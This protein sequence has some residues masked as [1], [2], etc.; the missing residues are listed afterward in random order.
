MFN[1]H[2]ST[3]RAR[4][5]LPATGTNDDNDDDGDR[6]EDADDYRLSSEEK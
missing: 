4:A 3:D 5:C 1:I 2:T 6:D